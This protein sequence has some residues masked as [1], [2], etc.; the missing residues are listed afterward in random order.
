MRA[1]WTSFAF[2]LSCPAL[3]ATQPL[4]VFSIPGQDPTNAVN[5]PV[6]GLQHALKSSYNLSEATKVTEHTKGNI[7]LFPKACGDETQ[8]CT[9]AC[10][11]SA[12]MFGNLET[13]HNCGVYR[14]IS[15]QW[16]RGNLHVENISFVKDLGFKS[17]SENSSSPSDIFNAIQNCQLDTYHDTKD[18]TK[19]IQGNR[20][21]ENPYANNYSDICTGISAPVVADV[22]GIGVP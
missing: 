21:T 19:N 20:G 18:Y 14:T 4:M 9:A 8:N 11:D 16:A 10:L 12:R 2:L 5:Y 3:E 17:S 13:L 22:G 7:T 1:I 6:F 15:E